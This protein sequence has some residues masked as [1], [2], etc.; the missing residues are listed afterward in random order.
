MAA[1]DPSGNVPP[2]L[3]L[4]GYSTFGWEGGVRTKTETWMTWW[5]VH[6]C[7]GGCHG[8]GDRGSYSSDLSRPMARPRV[9]P[10]LMCSAIGRAS[11]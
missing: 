4:D 2:L 7:P 3:P 8:G 1:V 10:V 6:F 9:Y 11:P 5:Q